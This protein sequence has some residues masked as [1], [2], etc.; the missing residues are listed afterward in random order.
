MLA[1]QAMMLLGLPSGEVFRAMNAA[2][3]ERYRLLRGLFERERMRPVA[4][5]DD[6]HRLRTVI[7]P[8]SAPVVGRRLQELDLA[9]CGIVVTALRH[10][11]H[12]CAAVP[13]F[14]LDAGDALILHG[15]RD[16]LDA[17]DRFLLAD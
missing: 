10:D 1:L 4:G 16:L 13:N 11:G 14:V 17:A 9:A 7:L 6:A 2:R 5:G 12:Y 15:T 3:G 8:T